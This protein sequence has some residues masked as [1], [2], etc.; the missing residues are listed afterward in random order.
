VFLSRA[1]RRSRKSSVRLACI[2]HAASVRPEPGSNSSWVRTGACRQTRGPTSRTPNTKRA[3]SRF[4][5]EGTAAVGRLKNQGHADKA[6]T[7]RT[8]SVT[9]DPERPYLQI[10]GSTRQASETTKT[11]PSRSIAHPAAPVKSADL[12]FCASRTSVQRFVLFLAT[13]VTIP[14]RTTCVKRS[15]G[16]LGSESKILPFAHF[17]GG[18]AES[19]QSVV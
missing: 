9:A 13:P 12:G 4:S 11:P 5:C 10:T 3:S 7:W 8:A 19:P 6:S 17:Y 14:C 18:S 2:R 1:P 16:F 15:S